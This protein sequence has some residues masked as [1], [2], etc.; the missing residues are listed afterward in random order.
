MFYI[1]LVCRSCNESICRAKCY[2]IH[3]GFDYGV[4]NEDKNCVCTPS[5]IYIFDGIDRAANGEYTQYSL[6]RSRVQ[7]M[8][9]II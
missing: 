2:Y 1:I 8:V 7:R 9:N 4:C 3:R 5:D 6:N